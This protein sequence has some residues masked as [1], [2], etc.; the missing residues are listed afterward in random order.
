MESKADGRGRYIRIMSERATGETR[1]CYRSASR[2]TVWWLSGA[3][4]TGGKETH[5][6]GKP[7]RDDS[8]SEIYSKCVNEHLYIRR[9]PNMRSN[10]R[11]SPLELGIWRLVVVVVVFLQII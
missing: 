8:K 2:V 9:S 1:K 11:V 5:H 6:T 3:E 4:R 7:I 10:I